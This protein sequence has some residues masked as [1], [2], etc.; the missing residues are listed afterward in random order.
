MQWGLCS[1]DFCRLWAL[2]AKHLPNDRMS[3]EDQTQE[4][5]K[6]PNYTELQDPATPEAVVLLCLQIYEVPKS[7]SSLVSSVSTVL[8]IHFLSVATRTAPVSVES[9]S[10]FYI[11]TADTWAR[12]PSHYREIDLLCAVWR[13]K[14]QRVRKL[15]WE[16]RS[17]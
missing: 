17:I 7:F 10:L 13:L 1:G 11:A 14:V 16:L 12:S 5:E 4:T 2:R 6:D 9:T 15:Q 3:M 8:T